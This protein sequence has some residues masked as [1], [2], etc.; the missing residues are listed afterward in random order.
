M[1]TAVF[2]IAYGCLEAACIEPA[3]VRC[4]AADR[5]VDCVECAARRARSRKHRTRR[6]ATRGRCETD[7]DNARTWSFRAPRTPVTQRYDTNTIRWLLRKYNRQPG[8]A[9]LAWRPIAGCCHL[10]NLTACSHSHCPSESFT[11]TPLTLYDHLKL[12]SNGPLYI[13]TVIGTLATFRRLASSR[14]QCATKS[15]R[16]YTMYTGWKFHGG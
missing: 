7:Q 16:S 4:F 8:T 14:H 15:R 10:T 2:S 1:W 9:N 11:T 3:A 6:A 13:N 5:A 12:Q